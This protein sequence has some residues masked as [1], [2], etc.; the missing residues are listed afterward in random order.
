MILFEYKAHDQSQQR[1][2]FRPSLRHVSFTD[3]SLGHCQPVNKCG[4]GDGHL[5][6]RLQS[7]Q[8]KIC[9][10]GI[11]IHITKILQET[12]GPLERT[13]ALDSICLIKTFN[14]KKKS[15]K[16]IEEILLPYYHFIHYSHLG[17]AHLTIVGNNTCPRD[18]RGRQQLPNTRTETEFAAVSPHHIRC[19]FGSKNYIKHDYCYHKSYRG[20][21]HVPTMLYAKTQAC[22]SRREGRGGGRGKK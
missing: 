3:D 20:Q 19:M 8:Y 17:N 4:A 7:V 21:P 13:L 16:M 15:K 2:H 11:F 22:E 14:E 5:L 9:D 12:P 6:C 1:A 18:S 10:N